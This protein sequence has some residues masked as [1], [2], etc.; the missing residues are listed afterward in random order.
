MPRYPL[1]EDGAD[2]G[3][4]LLVGLVDVDVA[5]QDR[6]RWAPG[7]RRRLPV[8]LELPHEILVRRVLPR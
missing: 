8:Q 1:G 3:A 6:S 7:P 2:D 4:R 5:A